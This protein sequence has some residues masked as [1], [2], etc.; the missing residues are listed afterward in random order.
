MYLYQQEF[1]ISFD[2]GFDQ[3]RY[4]CLKDKSWH[5]DICPSFYFIK[6]DTYYILWVN[7]P[8]PQDRE[9]TDDSRYTIVEAVNEGD[10]QYPEIYS[11]NGE[12]IVASESIQDIVAFLQ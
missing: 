7:F 11:S 9:N 2:L 6:N 5:N 4:S 3:L 8:D 1:G 12:D 10:V